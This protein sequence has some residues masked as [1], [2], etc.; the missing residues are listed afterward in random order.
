MKYLLKNLG[1]LFII[2]AVVILG[3]Y[4]INSYTDNIYLI[5]SMLLLIGGLFV[6]IILNRKVEE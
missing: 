1:I 3:V 5:I 4:A 2:A 6:H